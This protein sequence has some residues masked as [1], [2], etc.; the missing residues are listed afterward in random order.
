M[1]GSQEEGSA[2]LGRG[3][4]HGG[5]CQGGNDEGRR[6]RE[7]NEVRRAGRDQPQWQAGP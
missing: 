4:N 1:E 5:T 7:G 2:R 6:C 3:G